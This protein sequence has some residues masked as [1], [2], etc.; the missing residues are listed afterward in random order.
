[1]VSKKEIEAAF[2]IHSEQWSLCTPR[3]CIEL[4]L[5]AAEQE[6]GWELVKTNECGC[7]TRKSNKGNYFT[8]CCNKCSN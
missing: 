2:K 6:R 3:R 5:E 8:D 7:Q 4:A 1:M